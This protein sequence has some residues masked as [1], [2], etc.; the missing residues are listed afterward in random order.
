M[1]S[2]EIGPV[3]LLIAGVVLIGG[4]IYGSSIPDS[5]ILLLIGI[6][7]FAAGIVSFLQR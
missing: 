6:V 5:G 7:L 4:W 2:S 1:A 3:G